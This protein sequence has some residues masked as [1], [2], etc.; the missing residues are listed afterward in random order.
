MFH[1]N[2]TRVDMPVHLVMGK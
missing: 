2:S 1:R